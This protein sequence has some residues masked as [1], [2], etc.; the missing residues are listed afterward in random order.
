MTRLRGALKLWDI[1]CE[2]ALKD[3]DP[4]ARVA[5]PVCGDTCK[6]PTSALIFERQCG[7]ITVARDHQ[8][9]LGKGFAICFDKV[10]PAQPRSRKA[11]R[12]VR[13]LTLRSGW[14]TGIRHRNV[15]PLDRQ[16]WKNQRGLI[17]TQ[18]WLIAMAKSIYGRRLIHKCFSEKRMNADI[19]PASQ[20]GG[21]DG[22]R[23]RLRFMRRSD[24]VHRC[25]SRP[26][27]F[28]HSC[29]P[30]Q[31]QGQRKRRRVTT[32]RHA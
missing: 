11:G 20:W 7:Q 14:P 16:P 28:G 6:N 23:A 22:P 26:T 25:A 5:K 31:P 8:T 9:S 17:P 30:R 15:F 27:G 21:K 18:E 32:F 12:G 19:Y 4:S 10:K 1:P 29:W 2:E 24:R 3:A 13:K